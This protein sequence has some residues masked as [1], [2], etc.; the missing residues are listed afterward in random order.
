VLVIGGLAASGLMSWPVAALLLVAYDLMA[1]HTYLATY[2]AGSFKISYGAV[3]GTE[4]RVILAAVNLLVMLM[5]SVTIAGVAVL[6]FDIVGV[7]AALGL[8]LLAMVVV[9]KTSILLRQQD[10][11]A[12]GTR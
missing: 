7:M 11:A 3:G 12:A 1:I 10:T 2:T 4:L 8:A 5:P 6:V 9:P